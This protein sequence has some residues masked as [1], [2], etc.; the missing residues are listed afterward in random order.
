MKKEITALDNMSLIV[1]RG[2]VF[3]LLGPNGAGKSTLAKL[4][5]GFVW[6]TSGTISIS[7]L[8]PAES[9]SRQPVGYLPEHPEFPPHLSVAQ[10]LRYC[11]AFRRMDPS[12]VRLRAEQLA[13][14]L[15]MRNKLRS[16][17]RSLSKGMNLRLA[18]AT[19]LLHEPDIL[20]LDEPSDGLDP[21]GRIE[22]RNLLLKLKN[23]G[24][25]ILLNS[26]ILSEVERISD[27]VA[28]LKQ[29]RILRVDEMKA[30]V[31]ANCN[32]IVETRTTDETLLAGIR[33]NFPVKA[34]G[35][36][37][38]IKVTDASGVKDLISRLDAAGA[39]LVGIRQERRTLE[40]YYLEQIS[41]GRNP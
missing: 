31:G 9:A 22:F 29:G 15:G 4:L 1:E 37:W 16:P 13:D 28:L 40:D 10:V 24:K 20:V 39:V 30:I 34:Q 38:L 18:M 3:S 5:L 23:N 35:S 33:K 7:G 12:V 2:E 36:S 14:L 25:T 41:Y 27:R 17:I 21:E 8:S 32:Y 26:H 11:G 6:P 19:A